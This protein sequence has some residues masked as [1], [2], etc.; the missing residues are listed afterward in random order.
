MSNETTHWQKGDF[1]MNNVVFNLRQARQF[2]ELSLEDAAKKIG[3]APSTLYNWEQSI[4]Y[5]N[6]KY[7][8]NILSAYNMNIDDISFVSQS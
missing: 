1:N 2:R 7:I 5:P 8:P 6:A 4:S 3:V